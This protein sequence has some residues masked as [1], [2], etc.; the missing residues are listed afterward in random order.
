MF[1]SCEDKDQIT[2]T[3]LEPL[4]DEYISSN[5]NPDG[6]NQGHGCWALMLGIDFGHGEWECSMGQKINAG[7]AEAVPLSG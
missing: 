1:F 4:Q 3:V 7:P 6:E 2:G 5:L